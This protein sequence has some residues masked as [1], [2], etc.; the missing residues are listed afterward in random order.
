ME[1][2]SFKFG[3]FT[4][5]PNYAILGSNGQ[6]QYIDKKLLL[7]DN[8]SVISGN[9]C[10]SQIN[11]SYGMLTLKHNN[12]LLHVM[13]PPGLSGFPLVGQGY[14]NSSVYSS[15]VT[16][17]RINF[18]SKNLNQNTEDNYI[19][20]TFS[21]D[22]PYIPNKFYY[23]DE[24]SKSF[25][26]DSSEQV[27]EN[28]KYYNLEILSNSV[29]STGSWIYG[30]NS[31]TQ[32]DYVTFRVG[33]STQVSVYDLYAPNPWPETKPNRTFYI[34][35][36]EK[37]N[38]QEYTGQWPTFVS[39]QEE[40]EQLQLSDPTIVTT[41]DI[42]LYTMSYQYVQPCRGIL[43]LYHTNGARTEIRQGDTDVQHYGYFYLPGGPNSQFARA[44][45]KSNSSAF[46]TGKELIYVDQH[47]QI[48][49]SITTIG[50]S[51]TPVYLKG[52]KLTRCASY[53]PSVAVN[54]NNQITITVGGVE[55]KP[56]TVI[57][58]VTLSLSS[59]KNEGT[60]HVPPHLVATVNGV[61]STAVPI[62]YASNTNSGFVSTLE[63]TFSG[64]KTFSSIVTSDLNLDTTEIK[65]QTGTKK[66]SFYFPKNT[67]DSSEL[68]A[69][70]AWIG[71]PSEVG[72]AS[73]PVYVSANGELTSCTTY[74][75]G[76][77]VTLN[78]TSKGGL[79]ATFFAPTSS[80]TSGQLLI[81]GGNDSAP[82]WID[83]A[84]F[85]ATLDGSGNTITS[86]YVSK[87]AFQD[88]QALRNQ[89]RN[90]DRQEIANTLTQAKAYTDATKVSILGS[91]EL[92]ATYDTLKEI[93]A[94]IEGDGVNATELAEAIAV[95]VGLRESGDAAV[96]TYVNGLAISGSNGISVD[97][98]FSQGFTISGV[99]AT[100]SVAGIVSTGTQS[101]KGAKT[102]TDNVTIQG[103]T[104]L[105]N[106]ST[107]TITLK[108][109]TVLTDDVQYGGTFPSNPTEGQI[110]FKL[111]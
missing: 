53:S 73:L 91:G 104:T 56:D 42:S 43:Q 9:L 26:L 29:I 82:Q 10:F 102:F 49:V 84:T 99:N 52:G 103:T 74:A 8:E 68:T 59:E 41:L 39:S 108:G 34:Y 55:S 44:V 12:Q 90:A 69:Y 35:V 11:S 100:P 4:D 25:K 93:A 109:K 54:N 61:S 76:T 105:G 7:N 94:W 77:A 58:A 5:L 28:R 16:L 81:S 19:S 23:Y 86:Y 17:S 64:K 89:Y 24:E 33:N 51:I 48:M 98:N 83:S 22:N 6:R 110:F 79:T 85:R 3:W 38:Y 87:S 45:W 18:I 1:N 37:K 50:S 75:G 111:I 107:D 62:P 95:E 60:T 80:G 36:L 47:G 97:G 96:Q 30:H 57:K 14:K 2:L 101:F 21:N 40:K 27:N 13:P 15:N 46:G 65:N 72:G 66:V 78:N 88:E 71:S 20:V 32:Q 92:S 63:Q 106:E 70:A 67:N 31:S